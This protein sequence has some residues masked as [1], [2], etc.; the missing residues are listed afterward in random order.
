MRKFEA[1]RTEIKKLSA[2]QTKLKSLRKVQELTK[3]EFYEKPGIMS[4]WFY[5]GTIPIRINENKY[6]LRHLFQTYAI[7]KGIDRPVVKKPSNYNGM[8]FS[9]KKVQDMVVKFK[10][11]EV[12]EDAV[13]S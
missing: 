10:P 12:L 5:A 2:E 4:Q 6:E 1:I 9:E 7:L 8:L 11:L 3:E 13:G